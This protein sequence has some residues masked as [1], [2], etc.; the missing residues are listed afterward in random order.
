MSLLLSVDVHLLCFFAPVDIPVHVPVVHLRT[1]RWSIRRIRHSK[2]HVR[3]VCLLWPCLHGHKCFMDRPAYSRSI[4]WGGQRAGCMFPLHALVLVEE[5]V[6]VVLIFERLEPVALL[7]HI[8][9]IDSSVL[10]Y[11]PGC[12]PSGRLEPVLVHRFFAVHRVLFPTIFC[13]WSPWTCCLCSTP[14]IR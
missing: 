9:V 11:C 3:H 13:S 8:D 2:W 4:H 10:P 12:G 1:C 5:Q 14:R 7:K 6:V